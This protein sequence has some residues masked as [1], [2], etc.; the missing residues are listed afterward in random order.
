M[1]DIG[2]LGNS[3]LLGPEIIIDEAIV[4]EIIIESFDTA[5]DTPAGV[6][7]VITE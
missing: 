4:D 3:S 6:E 7:E 5:Q 2:N 1:S